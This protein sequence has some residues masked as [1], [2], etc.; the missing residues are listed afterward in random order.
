VA[1]VERR[2]GV[3]VVGAVHVYTSVCVCG[4][5]ITKTFRDEYSAQTTELYKLQV[6]SS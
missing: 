4:T 5:T 6:E 1:G 2:A 3:P